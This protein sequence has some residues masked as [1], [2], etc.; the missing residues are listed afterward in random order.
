MFVKDGNLHMENYAKKLLLTAMLQIST[1]IRALL[2]SVPGKEVF[3]KYTPP[4]QSA[5][6]ALNFNSLTG[7]DDPELSRLIA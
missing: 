1:G 6:K 4:V 2:L 7:L 5:L 3:G